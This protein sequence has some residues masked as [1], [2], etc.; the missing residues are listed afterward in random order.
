[1]KGSGTRL[2]RRCL[3][4]ATV[5][6]PMFQLQ[7]HQTSA[8]V[9]VTGYGRTAVGGLS[10]SGV[11]Q[12]ICWLWPRMDLMSC[13]NLWCFGQRRCRNYPKVKWTEFSPNLGSV[14]E[15]DKRQDTKLQLLK[16]NSLQDLPSERRDAPAQ[17][18]LYRITVLEMTCQ[19]KM[20][21]FSGAKESSYRKFCVQTPN[22]ESTWE[23]NPESWYQ[24][25]HQGDDSSLR[26]HSWLLR[27]FLEDRQAQQH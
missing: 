1:M 3:L 11:P 18:T 12:V 22:K 16:S 25:N 21:W 6:H 26:H 5:R 7:V 24:C 13:C 15:G 17:V 23:Q 9:L 14:I 27:Q 20:S 10:T 8:G 19:C 2:W 4:S